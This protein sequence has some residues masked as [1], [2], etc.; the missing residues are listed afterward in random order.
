[1]SLSLLG[2]IFLLLFFV[3]RAALYVNQP[4]SGSTCYGGQPC[5]IAW[6]DDGESP[7]LSDIGACYVGLYYGNGDL[8]QEIEPVNVAEIHS[9]SFTPDSAAGSDSSLYYVNFTSVE[10]IINST[11]Y[12]QYSV[13]FALS[14]MYGNLASHVA[15]D[16]AA[17]PVP[18]SVLS[19]GV[20]S[21]SSTAT[22][23][24]SFSTTISLPSISVATSVSSNTASSTSSGLS[25]SYSASSTASESSPSTSTVTSSAL[26]SAQCP[27]GALS[28]IAIT[29][30]MLTC[31]L[32]L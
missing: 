12:M 4:L 6:V 18:S 14:S 23:T 19:P 31:L 29:G 22:I 21:V 30:L 5:T 7:L 27:S 15:S 8:I 16:T 1:M 10:L 26:R 2:L 20:D 11:Y 32:H 17:I 28:L 24:N 9:L 13:D 25:R 3:A